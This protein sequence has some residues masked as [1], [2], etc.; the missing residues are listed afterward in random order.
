[1]TVDSVAFMVN[2]SSAIKA[3]ALVKS[4]LVSSRGSGN[5]LLVRGSTSWSPNELLELRRRELKRGRR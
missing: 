4:S 5:M 3:S 1:M 2:T